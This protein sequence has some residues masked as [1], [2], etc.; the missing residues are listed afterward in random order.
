MI[1]TGYLVGEIPKVVENRMLYK[2][3]LLV[4]G[5]VVI[6]EQACQKCHMET[7]NG[8]NQHLVQD[9]ILLVV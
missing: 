5:G 7:H 3:Q 9:Q 6:H 4:W 8:K 1:R 2:L